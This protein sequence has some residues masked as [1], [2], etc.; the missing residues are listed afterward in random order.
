MTFAGGME[1]SSAPA[2]AA[3]KAEALKAFVLSLLQWRP[4]RRCGSSRATLSRSAWRPQAG[5]PMLHQLEHPSFD[6]LGVHLV[7]FFSQVDLVGCG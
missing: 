7:D 2:V 4:L 3:A 6:A 1:F 5:R